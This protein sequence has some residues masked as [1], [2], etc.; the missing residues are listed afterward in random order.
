MGLSLEEYAAQQEQQGIEQ[1]KKDFADDQTTDG[2]ARS[3]LERQQAQTREDQARAFDVYKQYQQNIMLT[4]QLDTEIIKGLQA[5]EPLPS[6]F[7]KAMK[8]FYLC[9]GAENALPIIENTLLTVYGTGLKEA[10]VRAMQA[11]QIQ[12]RLDNL[13]TAY[14]SETNDD[15]RKRLQQAIR[16]HEKRLESV[17]ET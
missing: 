6:L 17:K 1:A 8:A 12:Q 14:K 13:R 4:G 2:A 15:D 3:P 7:L 9:K 5:G 10:E 11:D 16:M